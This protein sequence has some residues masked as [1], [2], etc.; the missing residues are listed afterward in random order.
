MSKKV[1]KKKEVEDEKYDILQLD[2]KIKKIINDEMKKLN[3]Y[4][5]KI[6]EI[7]KMLLVE[8][9]YRKRKELEH[10]YNILEKKI[11][12]IENNNMF[13]EYICLSQKIISEY[14]KLL[15]IPVNV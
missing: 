15:T 14:I 9:I 10:E 1:R 5:S 12:D 2:E 6:S 11:C 4:K 7:K 13:T 8:T 3:E